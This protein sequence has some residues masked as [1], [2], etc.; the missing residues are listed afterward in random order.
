MAYTP[1]SVL[2]DKKEEAVSGKVGPMD[3]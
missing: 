3:L 1:F 2:G